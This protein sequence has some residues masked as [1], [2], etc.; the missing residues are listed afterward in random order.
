MFG[1]KKS[2][3]AVKGGTKLMMES[4]HLL[5]KYLLKGD[6]ILNMTDTRLVSSHKGKMKDDV[7]GDH[8]GIPLENIQMVTPIKKNAI[9]VQ[10]TM[11]YDKFKTD[12]R[13]KH[14]YNLKNNDAILIADEIQNKL[15]EMFS[16]PAN[17]DGRL[18][19]K[20]KILHTTQALSEKGDGIFYVTSE[21]IYF[22]FPKHGLSFMLPFTMYR[23]CTVE[24]NTLLIKYDELHTDNKKHEHQHKFR[25]KKIKPVHE[26]LTKTYAESAA[27]RDERFEYLEE[28]FSVLSGKE[29]K[30][31]LV[32]K[33]KE[34]A[35]LRNYSGL[36]ARTT[37]QCNDNALELEEYAFKLAERIFADTRPK[38]EWCYCS[39]SFPRDSVWGIRD[40]DRLVGVGRPDWCVDPDGTPSYDPKEWYEKMPKV[41][42]D[43]HFIVMEARLV[44][45]A[46]FADV[47]LETIGTHTDSYM[48]MIQEFQ[49]DFDK[50]RAAEMN[51]VEAHI[52]LKEM[53]SSAETADAYKH[54]MKNP[55]HDKYVHQLEESKEIRESYYPKTHRSPPFTSGET[56]EHTKFREQ[57]SDV[58]FS[59]A[60]YHWKETYAKRTEIEF[61]T[62]S[63]RI[64]D[65]WKK[66]V[67]LENFTD[68]S[69]PSWIRNIF[70]EYP[71]PER[72][73]A[74][75][76]D[77]KKII[78]NEFQRSE[79]IKKSLE[80]FNIDG[81]PTEDIINND[82]W[83]DRKREMWFSKC[84]KAQLASGVA[85]MQS[86]EARKTCGYV[87]LGFKKEDVTFIHGFPAV[88]IP[89]DV[90]PIQH[91][92]LPYRVPQRPRYVILTTVPSSMKVQKTNIIQTQDV[93]P[94]SENL[95]QTPTA[96]ATFVTKYPLTEEMQRDAN[97]LV[98]FS[99]NTPYA[100]TIKDCFGLDKETV[101]DSCENIKKMGR[102]TGA[103]CFP[104]ILFIPILE[105]ETV[106]PELGI[107]NSGMMID[108]PPLVICNPKTSPDELVRNGMIRGVP[109]SAES[110]DSPLCVAVRM[111]AQRLD[112]NY[113]TKLLPLYERLRRH[114]FSVTTLCGVLTKPSDDTD[115]IQEFNMKQSI[116]QEEVLPH[117]DIDESR[118][119]DHENFARY[120]ESLSPAKRKDKVEKLD[121]Y[122]TDIS[123]MN[124][125]QIKELMGEFHLDSRDSVG[126]QWEHLS[127]TE[128]ELISKKYNL[129]AKPIS[130]MN[131]IQID[132]LMD[133]FQSLFLDDFKRYWE[134]L[135]SAEKKEVVKKLNLYTTNLSEM[136]DVHVDILINDK[137]SHRS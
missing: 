126:K 57:Y 99:E 89:Y 78:Q 42:A 43:Y 65:A 125:G 134:T 45:C 111:N 95:N 12:M 72:D 4:E 71:Y 119:D 82:C 27:R 132:L 56:N 75:L 48:G 52:K 21:S 77:L 79:G 133:E 90:F 109:A 18:L 91:P 70:A 96:D 49:E 121:L 8:M 98:K 20:E 101:I 105:Y 30:K 40:A 51:Y 114:L 28:K 53:D 29:L 73:A 135:P 60:E 59:F 33:R 130:E 67:E 46:L 35:I 87:A 11:R 93:K 123:E 15:E 38:T 116:P 68:D 16:Y 32:E 104:S 7:Y 44:L 41:N 108:D 74:V 22:E 107:M 92:N 81:I 80:S 86:D 26:L 39:L 58:E 37:L 36:T 34:P 54:L 62:L 5:E 50:H 23:E 6:K 64:Y 94:V 120:W 66:N 103:K 55:D 117:V 128:K 113:P 24:K 10:F 88:K 47:P 63:R 97:Y 76:P 110:D 115:T 3:S 69:D 131:D 19:T 118:S 2:G 14:Q 122:I 112:E 100:K 25:F 83:Y 9:L 106:D 129:P 13:L 137:R 102:F 31:I 136:N 127:P 124:V 1:R 85:T 61:L 84:E 17:E